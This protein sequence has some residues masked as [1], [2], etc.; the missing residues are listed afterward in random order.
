MNQF[1]KQRLIVC[2]IIWIG[3]IFSYS[4]ADHYSHSFKFADEDEHIVIGWMMNKGKRLYQDI[5]T[6]H[7][8]L[9]YAFSA[10]V[11]RVFHPDNMFMLIKRHRQVVF[12]WSLLWSTGLTLRFGKK[13]VFPLLL[14]EVLK[15]W[16]LGNEFLAESFAVYPA[17]YIFAV[18]WQ[19]WK[20][21]IYY[22]EDVLLGI[23]A[24]LSCLFL[25]PLAVPLGLLILWRWWLKRNMPTVVQ[26]A[27]GVCL[28]CI[29]LFLLVPFKDFFME[30]IYY[31]GKY[32]IPLLSQ[33]TSIG[34]VFALWTIP[35]R[36]WFDFSDALNQVFAG[37]GLV[38]IGCLA[39]NM[40]HKK[41]QVA[42][43]IFTLYWVW[44]FSNMRVIRLHQYYYSGFHIIPWLLIGFVI[45]SFLLSDI[46][47]T[48]S[49]KHRIILG[50]VI[51]IMITTWIALQPSIPGKHLPNPQTESYV[52]Y[53]PITQAA[54]VINALKN[55]TDTLMVFP[56]ESLI[57]W[58]TN[59]N[60]PTRQVTY[61]EWQYHHPVLKQGMESV[62]SNTPPR[63]IQF[64][65]DH[66][67]F[68]PLV[69]QVLHDSYTKLFDLP[70]VYIRTDSLSL[71]TPKQ[72]QQ[73]ASLPADFSGL[74]RDIMKGK[75]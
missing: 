11:Q 36:S 64:T 16:L 5:S 33:F 68:S 28:V 66:A 72:W 35:F 8:P 45:S 69:T 19:Q 41:W 9:N 32:G 23:S 46:F 62:L 1:W 54:Q 58:L 63:F 42:I 24:A 60:P 7:Q 12:L 34:D 57:H 31:N 13:M 47:N 67:S 20:D 2:L 14:F 27:I 56:N 38:W 70:G 39:W 15:Y 50:S 6:N 44:N 49:N 29:P 25:I 17:T 65:D 73:Y 75:L 74:N 40:S 22:P 55:P 48:I 18:V 10:V 52:Q 51:G 37:L 4:L 43:S 71:I 3:F 59:L 53:T 61:Y 21:R 26:F 30:T